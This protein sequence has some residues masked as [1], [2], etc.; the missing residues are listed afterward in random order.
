MTLKAKN[1][2]LN[3][4]TALPGIN[5]CLYFLIFLIYPET[6]DTE[7]TI[8][9]IIITICLITSIFIQFY[10]RKSL[11]TEIILLVIFIASLSM[12]SVRVIGSLLKYDSFIITYVISKISL[13]FKYLAL[14]SLLGSSLFS[15]SIKK[16]KIGSWV[17]LTLLISL[18]FSGILH[19]NTGLI[20]RAMLPHIIYW[21]E[22]LVFT[23]A[24]IIVTTV[25][26]IKSGLDAKNTDYIYLGVATFFLLIGL[27]LTFLSLSMISGIGTSILL[28]IGFI[29]YLKSIHNIILWN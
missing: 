1:I 7:T 23:I 9:I 22:E 25:T 17:L 20:H 13:F 28:T 26:F 2:I 29:I 21:M 6:R 5:F 12:Q 18:I 11:S 14:F 10:F 24:I 4:S 19:F 16:Q 27:Q 3:L 15:F 8:I